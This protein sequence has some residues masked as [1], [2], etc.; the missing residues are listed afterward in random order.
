MVTSRTKG[1]RCIPSKVN[2]RGAPRKILHSHAG[3]RKFFVD[4]DGGGFCA[5]SFLVDFVLWQLAGTARERM[6][7][8][9]LRVLCDC[10]RW[11][12]L[13][14]R[15]TSV[16]NELALL[17]C[18]WAGQSKPLRHYKHV[19]TR[20]QAGLATCVVARGIPGVPGI[21]CLNGTWIGC[22]R[23]VVIIDDQIAGCKASIV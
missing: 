18:W 22:Q 13:A 16:G 5:A 14:P 3:P 2:R 8:G 15:K 7:A 11:K 20:R 9:E 19:A 12:L 6:M 10:S 21:Q 4:V 17:F 1:A 23:L